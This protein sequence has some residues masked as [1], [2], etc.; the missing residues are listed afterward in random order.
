MSGPKVGPLSGPMAQMENARARYS[1]VAM[2]LM[3]PGE[4]A[5]MAPPKNAPKK[6]TTI[7]SAKEVA[8]AHGMMRIVVMNMLTMYTGRR[9]YISDMGARTMEPI[10]NPRTWNL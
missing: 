4:I 3:L 6:R 10:A 7:N 9:P 1:G 5:S 2:S 8:R